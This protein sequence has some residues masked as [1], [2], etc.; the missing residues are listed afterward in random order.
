MSPDSNRTFFLDGQEIPF[1]EGQ[2][3]FDAAMSAGVFIPHLCHNPDY[4]PH[5]SCRLCTVIVNGRPFA[6]CTQPAVAGQ[7][8]QSDTAE[9]R[10]MRR[11]LTQMLFVEGNHYCPSCEKSGSC[12]LQATA[13]H[14]GLQDNHYP[15]FFPRREMDASHADIILDRDR[16]ILCGL[17]VRISRDVDRKNVF[18]MTGR[19]I[20]TVIVVDSASGLL[21]DSRV[22]VEDEAVQHCPVG[23]IL[24]KGK[25]FEVPIGERVYDKEPIAVASVR[26]FQAREALTHG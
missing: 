3:V 20:H 13:Y 21:K 1:R 4:E 7:M 23:A 14:L 26:R 8:V 15:Q 25:A 10:A 24:I 16:C 6:S 9:L 2:S 11:T 18:A 5:S 12:K 22:T 17:C 19:G